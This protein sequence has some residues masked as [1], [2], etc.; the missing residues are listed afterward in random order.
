MNARL[1]ARIARI[2]AA[3]WKA[4]ETPDLRAVPNTMSRDPIQLRPIA[5]GQ[6][7]AVLA[8]MVCRHLVEATPPIQIAPN[9]LTNARIRR[10][11]RMHHPL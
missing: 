11:L 10:L 3:Q 2:P 4:R 8:G 9:P 7:D 1:A 6:R 5:W